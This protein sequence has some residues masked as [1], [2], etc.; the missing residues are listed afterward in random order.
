MTSLTF[1]AAAMLSILRSGA[2]FAKSDIKSAFWIV[3]IRIS[4]FDLLGFSLSMLIIMTRCCHL[5]LGLVL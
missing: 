1:F 4:D 3:S 5:V 2:Y